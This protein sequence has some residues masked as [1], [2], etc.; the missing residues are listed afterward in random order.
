[1]CFPEVGASAHRNSTRAVI[2]LFKFNSGNT[3][4]ICEICSK[5]INNMSKSLMSFYV[6][7]MADFEE[8]PRIVLMLPVMTLKKQIPAGTVDNPK[9]FC[10]IPGRYIWLSLFFI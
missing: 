3:R 5:F 2:Y 7:F 1:M 6:V 4:V 10:K 8:I 9:A